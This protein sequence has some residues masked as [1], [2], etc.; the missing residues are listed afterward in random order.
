MPSIGSG[1]NG[2]GPK[3]GLRVTRRAFSGNGRRV[4]SRIDFVRVGPHG[5]AASEDLADVAP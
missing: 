1:G 2:L 5:M 3:A 4:R